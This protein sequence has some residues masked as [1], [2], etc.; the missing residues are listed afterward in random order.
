[1]YSAIKSLRV[2]TVQHNSMNSHVLHLRSDEVNCFCSI[3]NFHF[4]ILRSNK[5]GDKTMWNT[6][7]TNNWKFLRLGFQMALPST[8]IW[9][10]HI[11]HLWCQVLSIWQKKSRM[12]LHGFR[13]KLGLLSGYA[14]NK[15]GI[16]H[17]CDHNIETTK[18]NPWCIKEAKCFVPCQKTPVIDYYW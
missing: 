6:L 13:V 18:W 16:I 10:D 11:Y 7:G 12:G 3:H 1:L 8:V 17:V 14:S 5:N 2:C 4:A 9:W 15:T